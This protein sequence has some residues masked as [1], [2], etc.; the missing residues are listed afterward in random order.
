MDPHRTAIGEGGDESGRA[1]PPANR[2]AGK[3][4][5]AVAGEGGAGAARRTPRL[6]CRGRRDRRHQDVGRH[7]PGPRAGAG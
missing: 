4:A 7:D 5:G 1:D 2:D 3:P 6:A